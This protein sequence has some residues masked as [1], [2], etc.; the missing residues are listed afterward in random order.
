MGGWGGT[1]VW[2]VGSEGGTVSWVGGNGE[3]VGR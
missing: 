1:V 2:W 3:R